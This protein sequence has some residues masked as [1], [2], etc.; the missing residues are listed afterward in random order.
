M[1]SSGTQCRVLPRH[2]SEEMKIWN[3]NNNYK[4]AD[5][6]LLYIFF[7]HI[8]INFYFS[9]LFLLPVGTV[10]SYFMSNLIIAGPRKIH[11]NFIYL[12]YLKQKLCKNAWIL[13]LRWLMSLIIFCFSRDRIPGYLILFTSWITRNLETNYLDRRKYI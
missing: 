7:Y 5:I 11:G 12:I 9:F 2:H 8:T 13:W 6:G 10:S 3:V 4:T 1:L